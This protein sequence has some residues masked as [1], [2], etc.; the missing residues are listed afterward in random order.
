MMMAAPNVKFPREIKRGIKGRDVLGHKRAISRAR[1][2]LYPWHDFTDYSGDKFMRAVMD[3]KRSKG[4]N[5]IPL[6][7][8][9]AHERLER[10]HSKTHPDQ[11][12]FDALAIKQCHDYWQ[13]AQKDPEDVIRQHIVDA[14]F[15]WYAHR[16]EIAYSQF[17]PFSMGKPPWVPIRWDCSAF[18]TNCHYAGGAP[19]P[20]GRGY[21]HQGYTG[22]LMNRGT[23]VTSVVNLRKGDLIFY[24]HTSYDRPGFPKGS[25]THVAVYAGI[26]NTIRMVVSNGHHPMGFYKWNYRTDINHFRHYKVA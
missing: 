15:F 9:T 26:Y 18:A 2:D 21:D 13:A 5:T 24:G 17:R 14:A 23:A 7:G 12:A 3:W 6:L 25:P 4:M 1:P 11:W 22:T 20:N 10:T 8:R 19:D 16:F